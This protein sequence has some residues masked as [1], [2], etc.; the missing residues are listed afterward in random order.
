MPPRVPLRQLV[1]ARRQVRKLVEHRARLGQQRRPR[2]R[3]PHL[4]GRALEQQQPQPLL[5]DADLPAQ[6]R[7]RHVEPPGRSA[8]MRLL[9]D[10]DEAAKLAQFDH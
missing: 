5:E 9:A 3:Q 10:R 7:L 6:W 4:A 2:R 1:R 8:E